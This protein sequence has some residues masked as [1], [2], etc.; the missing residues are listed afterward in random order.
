M[1]RILMATIEEHIAAIESNI[2]RLEAGEGE[3]LFFA[4]QIRLKL[5]EQ[6]LVLQELRLKEMAIQLQEA[7]QKSRS[8]NIVPVTMT[9]RPPV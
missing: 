8:S 2:E 7:A 5:A 6:D 3:Q 1:R 4:S 9:G